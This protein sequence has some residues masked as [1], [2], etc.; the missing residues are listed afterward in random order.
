MFGL[1]NF[2]GSCWVNACLQ[3]VFRIPEVQDRYTNGKHDTS[4][5]LDEALYKIWSSKGELGLK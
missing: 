5:V 3:A 4:N 2:R 1:Q